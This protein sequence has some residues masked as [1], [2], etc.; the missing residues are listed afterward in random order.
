M[1]AELKK[2]LANIQSR[3]AKLNVSSSPSTKPKSKRKRVRAGR[4][5]RGSLGFND[6]SAAGFSLAPLAKSKAGRKSNL[7]AGETRIRKRELVGVITG[8]EEDYLDPGV[9]LDVGY[10]VE[11]DY[12]QRFNWLSQIAKNYEKITWHSAV[13]Q[14]RPYVSL[15]QAGTFMAGCTVGTQDGVSPGAGYSLAKW[16]TFISNLAAVKEVP[17]SRAADFPFPKK[18]L[19]KQYFIRTKTDSTN[20]VDHDVIADV[21]ASPGGW[22]SCM[23]VTAK[24]GDPIGDL[25]VEYDVT[26]SAPRITIE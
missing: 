9:P 8:T 10:L 23:I 18:M 22:Q 21:I 1:A 11:K 16:R 24:K 12:P 13:M 6:N 26:L 7:S 17:I 25:W 20:A 3:L 5:K 14:W 4:G 19:G 15:T 2:E